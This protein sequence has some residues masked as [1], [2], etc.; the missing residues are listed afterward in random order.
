MAKTANK[1]EQ[2][3]PSLDR[4]SDLPTSILTSI[5]SLV[6]IEEAA[7]TSVL[8]KNWRYL[9]N[10]IPNLKLSQ[11]D[12]NRQKFVDN[13]WLLI[14]YNIL[15]SRQD[16]IERFS[17][18][19]KFVEDY[20]IDIDN[21]IIFLSNK[22]IQELSLFN[23]TNNL[24]PITPCMFL[25]HTL[26]KLD[27]WNC[28]FTIPL[29]FEIFFNLKTL[30]LIN[31]VS[32]GDELERLISCCPVLE[33]LRL[34]HC[35]WGRSL[36]I[37]APNLLSLEIITRSPIGITLKDL[38]QLEHASFSFVLEEEKENI[39]SLY[40]KFTSELINL[41]K[42][43]MQI[44]LLDAN[45]VFLFSCLLRN[46]PHLQDLG[47]VIRCQDSMS[48]PPR[49]CVGFDYWEKQKP[50]ECLMHHLRTVQIHWLD[51]RC[52]YEIGFVNYLL[53]S[54]HVLE[55]MSIGPRKWSREIGRDA[56]REL[57]LVRKASPSAVLEVKD[58]LNPW[59]STTVTSS[60]A[61]EGSSVTFRA[62]KGHGKRKDPIPGVL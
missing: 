37:R 3:C 25:C 49:H 58:A 9:F 61:S 19:F 32:A 35:T 17:F 62:G 10:S 2:K 60:G 6:P 23:T 4:I 42:L 38:N 52:D 7:R 41:K 48:G 28:K 26:R 53:M 36:S 44:S 1:R 43:T 40:L 14:V 18:L 55:R 15:L 27:L 13:R 57:S 12:L 31:V 21:F 24:Y 16:P 56:A 20:T 46:C 30:Q 47:L 39:R 45:A 5:L 29:P 34:S 59:R 54:A 22:G 51:L 50:L 8:S 11:I 33:K